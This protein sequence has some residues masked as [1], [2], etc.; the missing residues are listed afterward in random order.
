MT[1]TTPKAED[2]SRL[3]KAIVE[4]SVPN[5]KASLLSSDLSSPVV[6]L[7]YTMECKESLVSADALINEYEFDL[8][9]VNLDCVEL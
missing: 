6:Q 9:G 5:L 4:M 2:A 7:A 1:I 8:T 3:K